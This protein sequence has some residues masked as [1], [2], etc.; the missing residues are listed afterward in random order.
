MEYE[1]FVACLIILGYWRVALNAIGISFRNFR[2]NSV[3]SPFVSSLLQGKE[4][5]AFLVGVDLHPADMF[6][7][8][9][10]KHLYYWLLNNVTI[11]YKFY[12]LLIAHEVVQID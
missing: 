10:S 3:S 11:V 8:T 7:S 9:T 1:G 12:K 2:S 4:A 6:S 5:A